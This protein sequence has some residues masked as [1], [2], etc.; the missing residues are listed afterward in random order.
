M[1]EYEQADLAYRK[2]LDV[3]RQVLEAWKGLAELHS[4]TQDHGRALEACQVLVSPFLVSDQHFCPAAS[5]H[6]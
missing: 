5:A 4:A 1:K 3:D 2:A 6:L